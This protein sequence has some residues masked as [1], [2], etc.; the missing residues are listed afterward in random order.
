MVLKYDSGYHVTYGTSWPYRYIYR[1]RSIDLGSNW[2]V[3]SWGCSRRCGCP[4]GR[5]PFGRSISVL[6]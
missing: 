5:W 2:I 4:G 6:D 3:S 1:R